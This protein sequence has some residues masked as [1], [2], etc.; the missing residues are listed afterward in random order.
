MVT[1]TTPAFYQKN[2]KFKYCSIYCVYYLRIK[3]FC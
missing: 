3:V 1:T 2:I